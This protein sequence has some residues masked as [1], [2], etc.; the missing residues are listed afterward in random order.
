LK[1][2]KK[3]LSKKAVKELTGFDFEPSHYDA[4]YKALKKELEK[5]DPLETID[6]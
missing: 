1:Q 5:T 4:I 2:L 3:P 6:A